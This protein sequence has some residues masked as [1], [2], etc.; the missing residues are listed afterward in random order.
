MKLF[1]IVLLMCAFV[2]ADIITFDGPYSGS[3]AYIEDGITMTRHIAGTDLPVFMGDALSF[4]ESNGPFSFDGS[5]VEFVSDQPFSLISFDIVGTY[6][7]ANLWVNGNNGGLRFDSFGPPSGVI[8]PT[9]VTHSLDY[10]F[11]KDIFSFSMQ[12]SGQ[13]MLIDNIAF[14]RN[15]VPEPTESI[16]IFGG[17]LC[18]GLYFKRRQLI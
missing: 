11:F 12:G 7:D 3:G 15:S 13:S 4:T 9:L 6:S 1:V 2:Y 16:L 17:L 18:V 8:R 14:N 10:D 5:K